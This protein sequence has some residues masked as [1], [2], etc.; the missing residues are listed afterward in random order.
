MEINVVNPQAIRPAEAK[1]CT[2]R[3]FLLRQAAWLS[4]AVLLTICVFADTLLRFLRFCL[5]QFLTHVK[6]AGLLPLQ[7][8]G[9]A[10]T[11][12]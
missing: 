5:R 12:L 6:T 10:I 4:V 7:P 9:V 2:P 11:P 8:F 1:A 3:A